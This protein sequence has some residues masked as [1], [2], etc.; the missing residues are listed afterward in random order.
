MTE[1]AADVPQIRTVADFMKALEEEVRQ[2][3]NGEMELGTA[4]VIA[5][6]RN[7]EIQ[8]AQLNIHYQ[9]LLRQQGKKPVPGSVYDMTTGREV[10]TLNAGE[11][12]A[13]RPAG[14][15]D[16]G[17]EDKTKAAPA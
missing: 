2:I 5:K 3:K 13:P 4:R 7:L 1:N 6:Y 12:P 14:V 9:R 10:P 16:P 17:L 8:A 15:P 11:P